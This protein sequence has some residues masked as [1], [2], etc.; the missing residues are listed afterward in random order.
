MKLAE[1][2]IL[3]ADC[4]KRIEQLKQRLMRNAKSQEG[5]SPAENP[6][7][8]LHE[9]EKAAA[10]LQDLIQRIN[11]T[12]S[13]VKLD[14]AQTLSDALAVRDVL[15]VRQGVYRELAAAAT[16]TQDRYTKSEVKFKGNV[17]VDEIQNKADDIAKERREL[18]AKIQ[19]CNWRTDL[20]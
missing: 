5:D 4:Q 16:V 20:L 14:S 9:M 6:S 17:R 10:E 12:N 7:Q 13:E 1:A 11:K 15:T 2:L 19:E 8:L 3:R 18:D